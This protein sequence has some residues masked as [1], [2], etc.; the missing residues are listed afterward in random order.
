MEDQNLI[1]YIKNADGTS[2]HNLSLNKFVFSTVIMS[3]NSKIEGDFYYKDNSLAFSLTEYVE[4]K[5]IKYVLSNPPTVVKKGLLSDN[6]ELKGMT[7]YSCTFYHEEIELYNIPFTDIAI[8]SQE[9]QYRSEKRN[10]FWIGTITS[11]VTKIN[12]CLKGTKW[13][14]A[15]QP[16]FVDDGTLSDVISFSDQFISDVCK[17]AYETFKVPYVVDNYKILFGRPSNE[18]LSEDGNPYIFKFGQGVGLKNNDCSPKN[19][20]VVT[21]IAGYGSEQNI[22]YGYP[23]IK[24]AQGKVIDHPYTREYLMPTIYVES[25]RRKLLVDPNAPLIDYYDADNSYPTPINPVAP[26][27]HIQAFENI[28]PSIEGMSYKGQAIDI[29]KAVPT[30][31]GGWDDY[32]DPETGDVRQSYFTVTL[33]P[34]GFDLYAQAAVTGAMTFSMK[35][36]NALGANFEVAVDWEDVK[37]NFY[38]TD[39]AG[40]ITFEPDGPQRDL[41]KYPKSTEQSITLTLTKDLNTFGTLMPNKYQYPVAGDKFVILHIEMPQSYIDAAQTKLDEAM[42]RYMLENNMPLYDY[43]L[44]FDDY[45]LHTHENILSQIKENTIVRFQYGGE[46]LALSVKDITIKYGS[47]PLPNYNITLTDEVS[48]VLNQIGQIADGLSKLGSQVASLQ[49]MYGMDITAELN[50]RLSR[51]KDDT[52]Q[53]MIT[54]LRGLKIGQFTPGS[55]GGTFYSDSDGKSWA[56]MDYLTVRMKAFFYSLEIIKTGVIGGRQIITP[57][58]GIDCIKVEETDTA[59]KCYFL[60]DDGTTVVENRFR[61][62]DQA[63]SQDFNIKE[64]VYE[65]VS[66]HYYWRLVTEVGDD[67]IALSKTDADTGSDIPRVGD[68][69]SQLGNR[70]DTTRQN[71]IIFSAVDTFSPSITLYAGINSYSYL[72]KDYISY[73]VDKTTNQAYQ[74]I[75]GNSYIGDRN[76]STYIKFDQATGVEIKGTLVTKSGTNVD[77][78]LN[79]FQDQLDGVK[80]TWYGE[81]T[82]NLTNYPANEW[83]SDKLKERH[84][85]DVFT[86]IQPYV[87]DETTPDAG[88]SWRWVKTGSTWG[89]TQIADS[90]T[91]KAYLEAAKA[92]KA[93]AEAAAAANTA[94]TTINNMKTFTDEAFRDGIIDRGEAVA[95]EKYLNNIA[96]IKKSVDESYTKVYNNPLL[97]GTTKVELKTSYDAFALSV[98]ELID[99]IKS[100][101]ADGVTTNL[102]KA[103][104]D[105]KYTVFNT[106]YGD[107]IAYLNAANKFIQDAINTTALN[108]AQAAAD[109]AQAA[110]EAKKRLDNWAADGVISPTEKQGIKDEIARIDGDK[111]LITKGYTL[112]S[113]GTPS[114]YNTAHTAY[115]AILVTLSANTPETIVI[116]ANFASTQATYYTERTAALN[117]INSAAKDGI[118]NVKDEIAGYEYLKKAWGQSTTIEGGLILTSLA[119]F[120]YTTNGVYTVMSGINGIYNADKTGGGIASWYG[121]AMIDRAD[122]TA[123]NIP[124]NVA[125][126]V[127]RMDGSGYLADGA[128]WWDTTGKFFADPDSFIISENQ[129]GDYLKLFQIMYTD[130]TKKNISYIIPQ[131]PMQSL[132]IADYIEI[133]TSGYRIGVDSANGAIKVYKEDG[134]PINFYATGGVSALGISPGGGGGGGGLIETVYGYTDL[135]K[136]FSDSDLTDTFNAY[137]INQLAT[138]ISELEAGGGGGLSSVT[139]KLGAVEYASVEGI[140]SLPA[141]PTSLPASDVYAWA[142]AATKPSYAWSEI[143]SKPT[144]LGGY[145]ITDAPTKTGGGASGTWGINVTGN[146]AT[147]TVA[148]KLG[149]ATVGGTARGIYLNAGVAT[150]MSATVGNSGLPVYMNAGTI[151]ACSNTFLTSANYNNYS[152]SL[153]G[154]NATGMWGISI[155]GSA[156][157]LGGYPS[158]SFVKKIGDT[159]TGVLTVTVS[160]ATAAI[161]INSSA[162]ETG[163][164]IQNH[165]SSKAWVGWQSHTGANLYSYASAKYLSVRD[166]GFPS[167]G[168]YNSTWMMPYTIKLGYRDDFIYSVILLWKYGDN[169]IH[170]LTGKLF[171]QTNGSS[172]YQAADVDLWFSRW[173]SGGNSDYAFRF[174]TY[175]QITNWDLVTCTYGGTTW[176]ALRHRNI[177]S[178]DLY[179]QGTY[180]NVTFTQVN[181]YNT[182]TGVLNAEINNSIVERNN[183][184]QIPSI[185]GTPYAL[186]TSNVASATKLQTPRTIFGKTFDGTG[187]VAGQGYFYGPDG[188][189]ANAYSAGG[190]QI[191]EQEL[192][193]ATQTSDA[194]APR[195]GFHWGNRFG[196]CLIATT[197]G[198]KYMNGSLSSY[199]PIMAS[200]FYASGTVF[201]TNIDA[202]YITTTTLNVSSTSTFRGQIQA[203]LNGDTIRFTGGST[204]AILKAPSNSVW[205]KIDF[206]QTGQ[207]NG[208][209]S[210]ILLNIQSS[211]DIQIRGEAANAILWIGSKGVGTNH[212][213]WADGAVTAK[214][215]SSDLRLKKDIQP[216]NAMNVVRKLNPVMFYWN[217]TAKAYSP[218]L[219]NDYR[220]YGLIAQSVEKIPELKGFA[221]NFFGE[222]LIVR[223]EKFIPITLQAI[224]EIDDKQT[225]LERRV[226]TLEK[227]ILRLGGKEPA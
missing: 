26:S 198:L 103:A 158:S 181:Y 152:P 217:D 189:T 218:A 128:V 31:E 162:V 96:S 169:G 197:S 172:R 45:F 1:L 25:V 178:T 20:K 224:K 84:E 97:A 164:L 29:F 61:V 107:F 215:S 105:S 36:G 225:T 138:R 208:Q 11:L 73:G 110:E 156:A 141:Y 100:A 78:A 32:I 98:T 179:F 139:V 9:A 118:Q 145:G 55:T 75:Y 19:N 153:T 192:V 56:E 176:W 175:G 104:V 80:E 190:L 130:S 44:V 196:S 133:G 123:G 42:K 202:S 94:N 24:D 7:K 127:I 14:A 22:P 117:A 106:K 124:S 91:S 126:A 85:G 60:A 34:L 210:N 149:T 18:I 48:I 62:G 119:Q 186:V 53:G 15:M 52:A 144:T 142:K 2:F 81:Y 67:Y 86:N 77:D 50:K 37:K 41:S 166:E 87:D 131:Y 108:A 12:Q 88:K 154:T 72:D 209:Y 13:S 173:D 226:E 8:D 219:R 161:G 40:N 160:S 54:F 151:T 109:A 35:S 199:Q 159:M 102:E 46:E 4:Y 21:R 64:G 90:D 193:L 23:I 28:R 120:G 74:K 82:P 122:Y 95:I 214:A 195:I 205:S 93:A 200:N 182:Q 121:G 5:G 92:A 33:Y 222:Y 194:Y 47:S 79:N 83:T 140:V 211:H 212:N 137:T 188:N 207:A 157:T 174:D 150:A 30:P 129:L 17:T 184:Y 65:N 16:G 220:N 180:H 132:Q 163:I 101:I 51:V 134:T 58:G 63:L 148:S 115:R 171:T 125:K 146:A 99:T 221:D 143:T 187:N 89:W 183:L 69:I 66:N 227:E 136:I 185:G 167:F 76:N 206:Y 111:D 223:Y 38:V 112:Y 49:A 147:A 27:F 203:G 59:Y 135:G 57:G 191:R 170:R 68:T 204:Q 201:T 216:F 177:Q 43:P 71:A 155:S 213:F 70:N 10:F 39:E 165:G 6:S 114:L 116:P 113:L 168:T 3:L